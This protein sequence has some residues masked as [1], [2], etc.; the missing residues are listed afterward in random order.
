M[1]WFWTDRKEGML[2][3]AGQF[4]PHPKARSGI[5]AGRGSGSSILE[6]VR[7]GVHGAHEISPSISSGSPPE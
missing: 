4:M 5:H 7:K 1:F 2:M 3:I 6:Y